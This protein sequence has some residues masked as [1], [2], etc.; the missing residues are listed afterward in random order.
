MPRPR[1][2][3]RPIYTQIAIP[4]DVRGR[5]DLHLFSPLEG[6]VPQGAYSN[7]II[8]LIKRELDRLYL[9]EFICG[10]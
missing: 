2:A 7:F 10:E 8:P 5:L 3:I 6:R 9:K 1:K 4:E